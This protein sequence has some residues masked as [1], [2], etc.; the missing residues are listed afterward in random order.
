MSRRLRAYLHKRFCKHS[1]QRH[2]HLSRHKDIASPNHD[3]RANLANASFSLAA[4]HL[5]KSLLRIPGN[6]HSFSLTINVWFY[7]AKWISINRYC[8]FIFTLNSICQNEDKAWN[9]NQQL[10]LTLSVCIFIIIIFS[11]FYS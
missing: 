10:M 4:I 6:Q 9:Y 1:G 2:C 11:I 5:E 3:D 7:M 8:P